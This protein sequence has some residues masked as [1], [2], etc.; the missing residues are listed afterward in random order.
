M[1]I[2]V[3]LMN[4]GLNSIVPQK[5]FEAFLVSRKLEFSDGR[6]LF[7]YQV[8]Q[9]EYSQLA[10]CLS[11]SAAFGIQNIDGRLPRWD[12]LFVLYASEWW[13]RN[14]Q[15]GVWSWESIIKS[16][17]LS[18]DEFNHSTIR[19]IVSKGLKKWKRELLENAQG[20]QYLGTVIFEGGIPLGL[21]KQNTGFDRYLRG[22]LKDSIQYSEAGYTPTH[23]A[24]K[25]KDML[26]TAFHKNEFLSLVGEVIQMVLRLRETYDLAAKKDPVEHLNTQL[27]TWRTHFPISLE[28]D[29]GNALISSLIVHSSRVKKKSDVPI[30]LCRRLQ[31]NNNLYSIVN[32]INLPRLVSETDLKDFWQVNSVGNKLDL[33][34]FN[35]SNKVSIATLTLVRNEEY[36]VSPLIKT[37]PS[38]GNNED[39]QLSF[40]R[41]GNA[42]SDSHPLKGGE[43]IEPELPVGFIET[44][45]QHWEYLSQGDVCT[46]QATLRLILPLVGKLT[47]DS[48]ANLGETEDGRTVCEI[49]N[50]STFD[51]D[52]N[53]TYQLKVKLE[54]PPTNVIYRI[55]SESKLQQKNTA[56]P[57]VI[58]SPHIT[59]ILGG[60]LYAEVP[61]AN[62]YWRVRGGNWNGDLSA[63]VGAVDIGVFDDGK[64]AY[65][66]KLIILPKDLTISFN[67]HIDDFN[68]GEIVF[69]SSKLRSVSTSTPNVTYFTQ[70]NGYSYNLNVV[71]ETEN[72]RAIDVLLDFE[73][74]NQPVSVKFPFPASG[75]RFIN[76]DGCQLSPNALITMNE[77]RIVQLE[78]QHND[79]S[80]H[81]DYYIDFSLRSKDSPELLKLAKKTIKLSLDHESITGSFHLVKPLIDFQNEVKRLFSL[82]EDLDAHL[83]VS[84]RVGTDKVISIRVV[85]Y[86]CFLESEK[87]ASG[88]SLY[89][90]DIEGS[91]ISGSEECLP[92]LLAKPL[93]FPEE[94]G[95]E[96]PPIKLQGIS[97]N[98]WAVPNLSKHSG[99]WL[100]FERKLN[101]KIRPRLIVESNFNGSIECNETKS[102]HLRTAIAESNFISRQQIF[103]RAIDEIAN[104]LNHKD[105]Q[106]VDAY[107]SEFNLLPLTTF[108]MWER[109]IK[110]DLAMAQLFF[111]YID[112]SEKSSYI[113]KF[114]QELPFLWECI[115]PETW[116]KAFNQ[117][118]DQLADA[119]SLL[120]NGHELLVKQC[121]SWLEALSHLS[122]TS[123]IAVK[124]LKHFD[125]GQIDK[126]SN[127]FSGHNTA[128]AASS[129]LVS[130][131]DDSPYQELVRRNAEE[132]WPS[133]AEDL[134]NRLIPADNTRAFQ[135]LRYLAD[136]LPKWRSSVV[137][138]PVLLGI[139]HAGKRNSGVISSSL[140]IHS[141]RLVIRFDKKWFK[142]AYTVG[143]I[144]GLGH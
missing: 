58:G 106:I 65:R 103:D 127:M 135:L 83:D 5:F 74:S 9:N 110:N 117:K 70:K 85:H 90:N 84:V 53:E 91:S 23:F 44:K 120:P 7:A 125:L 76:A 45:D 26:A 92:V 8:G 136:D 107:I 41:K 130:R 102:S 73:H 38:A 14:Y 12:A 133:L 79:P 13:R 108:V 71:A 25:R 15:G 144:Y 64:L 4:T 11:M 3:D 126:D 122:V 35:G 1:D 27:P 52:T 111:K 30:Y 97:T 17:E 75:G 72:P 143:F 48:N 69:F 61:Q 51:V 42:I 87:T 134:T 2:V 105:W 49:T 118:K 132:S 142:A 66:K 113:E 67:N 21:L 32:V 46:S 86:S 43:A 96:L 18:A 57:V 24:E 29:E 139:H 16:L 119:L 50:N 99:P 138:T 141:M 89:L 137:L 68:R 39:W 128:K 112:D 63:A 40:Y 82:S 56:I 28:G 124:A 31:N 37:L 81:Q 33:V 104:D 59:K 140:D 22:V 114:S 62:I 54:S 123:S 55:W 88:Y 36:K 100:I 20:K 47:G 101:S 116:R 80:L 60:S 93:H 6:P 77:L 10:N 115:S 121:L 78:V 94:R 19:H 109:F 95:F 34:A 98:Q 129:A 131:N